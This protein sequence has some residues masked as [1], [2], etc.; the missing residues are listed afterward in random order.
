MSYVYISYFVM[1]LSIYT[2]ICMLF[3]FRY[4]PIATYL[5]FPYLSITISFLLAGPRRC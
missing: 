4:K 3:A 2:H 1:S 5:E